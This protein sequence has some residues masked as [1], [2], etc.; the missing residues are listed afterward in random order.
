MIKIF[1]RQE[2][3]INDYN[4]VSEQFKKNDKKLID[5]LI[6]YEL[7]A[8]GLRKLKDPVIFLVG[9]ILILNGKMNIGE[10]IVLMMYSNNLVDYVVQL[11]Y[12]V[13]GINEFLIP[14]KRIND[15]LNLQELLFRL[16]IRR[17]DRRNRLW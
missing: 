8:S 17:L 1:N 3:E 12:A 11:I 9:G 4:K 10:I 6:Y 15:F 2:K 13:E 7:I 5:Y 14:T 16:L